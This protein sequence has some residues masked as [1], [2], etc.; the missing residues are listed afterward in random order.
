MWYFISS[1]I[2]Q[3]L[4]IG[5]VERSYSARLS[6][7]FTFLILNFTAFLLLPGQ[8][9]PYICIIVFYLMNQNKI[10]NHQKI[11]IMKTLAMTLTMMLMIAA[12]GAMGQTSKS[13]GFFTAMTLN[14]HDV[15]ELRLM[16]P[17]GT[18]VTVVVTDKSGAVV[19]SKRIKKQNN[20][21]ISHNVSTL[22]DGIYTY[23][24]KSAD[25][26]LRS[27]D[28]LKATDRPLIYKPIENLAEA[29]E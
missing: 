16:K 21:L 13:D 10:N 11:K 4:L 1:L 27:T 28:V 22:D 2:K 3:K 26:T 15:V 14:G 6:E 9:V 8:A 12:T 19:Y 7:H 25:Q 20:L 23:T 29:T 18:A 17:D 24:V 5:V